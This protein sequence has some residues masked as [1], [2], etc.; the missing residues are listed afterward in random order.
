[1]LDIGEEMDNFIIS[2]ESACDLDKATIKENDIKICPMEFSVDDSIIMSSG[3]DVSSKKIVDYLKS[4]ANIKTT[5]VNEYMAEEYLNELL[6]E[7]KDIL[8]ISFSSAMS[9]TFNNFANVAKRL[10]EKSTNKIYVVDSL[11]QSGGVGLLVKMLVDKINFGKIKSAKEAQD[12]VESVKLNIAHIFTVDDL[13]FLAKS[14]RVRTPIAL[15]GNLLQ[16][17]PILKVNDDGAM[18]QIK[19]TVG[20]KKSIKEL[21]DIFEKTYS[22]LSHDVFITHANC[23]NDAQI[24][25]QMITDKFN[26]NVYVVML[27]PVVA[28]HGGPGSLALFYTASKR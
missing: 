1:M 4:G 21:F 3:D 16:I 10:N 23:D 19:K 25:K 5:Q 12:Y 28:V 2:V 27:N 9:N 20:R 7:G 22:V 18:V 11:C 6:K 14:G 13:K 8:H 17:K 24:L 15:I 26:V